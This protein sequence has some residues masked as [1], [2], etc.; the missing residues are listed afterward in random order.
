MY[1]RTRAVFQRCFAT[2]KPG[3]TTRRFA[4]LAKPER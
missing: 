4:S 3:K 1:R 2:M